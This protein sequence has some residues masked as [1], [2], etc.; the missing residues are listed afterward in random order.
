MNVLPSPSAPAHRTGAT[1]A[2]AL[3]LLACVTPS[4][5]FQFAYGELK[6]SFDSNLSVGALY[7]LQDPSA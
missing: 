1:L 4:Q 6:G 7:R 3:G 2:V 5:A